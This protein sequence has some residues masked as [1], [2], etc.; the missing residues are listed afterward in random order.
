MEALKGALRLTLPFPPSVN[1]AWRMVRIGSRCRM[2]LSREGRAYRRDAC[3]RLAAL[4][5]QMAR[6]GRSLDGP[7]RVVVTLH[8]PDRRKR[9]VDNAM[10][11]LLDALQHAGVIR[12]DSQVGDLHIFRG[13]IVKG[14]C[15]IVEIVETTD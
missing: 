8:P 12:D 2:L 6:E 10:K 13:E 9:D 15:A 4:V 14:G 3:A 7:L 11:A 1:R 5:G